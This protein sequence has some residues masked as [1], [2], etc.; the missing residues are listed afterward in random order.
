MDVTPLKGRL[1]DKS[2]RARSHDVDEGFCYASTNSAVVTKNGG[3]KAAT[4]TKIKH[5]F[6]LTCV[7]GG[8]S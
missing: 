5:F 8:N 7:G 4:S 6:V 1:Q 2:S 3:E